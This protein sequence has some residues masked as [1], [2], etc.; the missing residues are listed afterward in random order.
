MTSDSTKVAQAIE[1]IASV[2]EENS[3]AFEEVA[4]SAEEM[5]AQVDL[6]SQSASSLAEMSQALQQVVNQFIIEQ[7]QPVEV[8][9]QPRQPRQ[10]VKSSNGHKPVPVFN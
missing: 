6:V 2:S 1:N 9:S 4:A 7:A 8:I 10:P 5:T 3:A